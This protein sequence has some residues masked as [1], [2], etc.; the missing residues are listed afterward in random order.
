MKLKKDHLYRVTW[1]DAF[2]TSDWIDKSD[3]ARRLK[4]ASDKPAICYGT[5][6]MGYKQFYV[7][8]TGYDNEQYF[9]LWS[10]PKSWIVDVKEI[11]Q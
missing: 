4:E 10:V 5:F 7:F 1:I 2:T 6:V 11:K 8:T 9:N 3:V